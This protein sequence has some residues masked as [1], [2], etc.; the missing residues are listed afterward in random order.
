MTPGVLGCDSPRTP[1]GSPFFDVELGEELID[2]AIA[3]ENCRGLPLALPAVSLKAS[4]SS[5]RWSN[6]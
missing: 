1:S 5:V 6:V 2:S 4:A 3:V